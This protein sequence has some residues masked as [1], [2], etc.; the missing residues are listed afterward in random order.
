MNEEEQAYCRI[1][2]EGCG[3]GVSFCA[4]WCERGG[5]V[6]LDPPPPKPFWAALWSHITRF[7]TSLTRPRAGRV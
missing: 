1:C 7:A 4:E 5:L 6:S 2:G 3:P